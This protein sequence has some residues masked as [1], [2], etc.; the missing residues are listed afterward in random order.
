MWH[1]AAYLGYDIL[2]YTRAAPL[3][4]KVT[5]HFSKMPAAYGALYGEARCLIWGYMRVRAD[6]AA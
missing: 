5:G 1:Y 6:I 4:F 2:L 3:P